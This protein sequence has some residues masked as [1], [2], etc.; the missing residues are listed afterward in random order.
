[1]MVHSQVD[2]LSLW[3]HAAQTFAAWGLWELPE[4][5][6]NTVY[7]KRGPHRRLLHTHTRS[8]SQPTENFTYK[9]NKPEVSRRG[10]GEHSRGGGVPTLHSTSLGHM[11]AGG[12]M[13]GKQWEYCLPCRAESSVCVS[14]CRLPPALEGN[15]NTN[16][17]PMN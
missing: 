7:P 5:K 13:A 9:R 3:G 15:I 11:T 1:M 6:W 12:P 16:G 10:T 14:A 4:H 17:M 2:V 8:L